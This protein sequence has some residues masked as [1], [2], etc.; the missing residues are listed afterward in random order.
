[1]RA[2]LYLAL[3]QGER[4]GS[5]REYRLEARGFTAAPEIFD[6][7]PY[8]SYRS[9]NLLPLDKH[10]HDYVNIIVHAYRADGARARGGSK[11]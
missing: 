5:I 8:R 2:L 7:S 6:R 9:W 11:F 4:V 3:Y 1:M 10:G